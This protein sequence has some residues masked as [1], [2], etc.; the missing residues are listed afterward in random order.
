M[1]FSGKT[2]PP[3]FYG[4]RQELKINKI[5]FLPPWQIFLLNYLIPR[6]WFKILG[7]QGYCDTERAGFKSLDSSPSIS[8][9]SILDKEW[10]QR[11]IADSQPAHKSHFGN[12]FGL[13]LHHWKCDRLQEDVVGREPWAGEGS[14]CE[15]YL[16]GITGSS[17]GVESWREL[18]RVPFSS[19][20]SF[21]HEKGRTEEGKKRTPWSLEIREEDCLTWL[22][23]QFYR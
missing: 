20:S 15:Y 10:P 14:S 2:K 12:S 18:E 23:G 3:K 1:C 11:S 22:W 21:L 19:V 16:Q 6:F 9:F 7:N 13:R 8:L 5:I 17:A 4:I